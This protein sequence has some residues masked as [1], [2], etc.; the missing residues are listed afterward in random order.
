MPL[1]GWAPPYVTDFAVMIGDST[2]RVAVCRRSSQ[3]VLQLSYSLDVASM[4]EPDPRV[5]EHCEL[6]RCYFFQ[7]GGVAA[8]AWSASPIAAANA[9]MDP[10]LKEAVARLEY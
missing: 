5:R 9:D 10:Q 8:A 1:Q 7:A 6:T 3:Q 4:F 2:S